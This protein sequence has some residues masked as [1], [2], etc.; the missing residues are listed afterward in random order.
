MGTPGAAA[1]G[2]GAAT[3]CTA[4]AGGCGT[5]SGSSGGGGS[6]GAGTARGLTDAE[7]DTERDA[8]RDRACSDWMNGSTSG[9][10]LRATSSKSTPSRG[11]NCFL[12]TRCWNFFVMR[13]R[14]QFSTRERKVLNDEPGFSG[15]A[16]CSNCARKASARSD[17]MSVHA[18]SLRLLPEYV[19]S[20]TRSTNSTNARLEDKSISETS[21]A[22]FC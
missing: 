9:A 4:L 6:A 5:P 1:A 2:A 12:S 7:R 13:P 18:L 14:L 17:S 22:A 3:G 20:A 8:E 10:S 19:A 16:P 11:S 21:L 15:R